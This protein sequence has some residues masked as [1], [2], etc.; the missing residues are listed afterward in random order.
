MITKGMS[1]WPG[2]GSPEK[3]A[4]MTPPKNGPSALTADAIDCAAPFTVPRFDGGANLFTMACAAGG[5]EWKLRHS[6]VHPVCSAD[7]CFPPAA[8]C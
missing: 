7:P 1:W 8:T 4:H 6:L 2:M 3:T 5:P